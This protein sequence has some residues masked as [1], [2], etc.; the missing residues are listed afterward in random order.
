MNSYR[1]L[2]ETARC[3]QES[4]SASFYHLRSLVLSG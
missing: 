1:K 4:A 2:S 3:H